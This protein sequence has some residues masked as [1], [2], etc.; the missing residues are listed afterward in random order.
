MKPPFEMNPLSENLTLEQMLVAQIRDNTELKRLA[1]E[2]EYL[3]R[4]LK[5]NADK[6]DL[7]NFIIGRRD[8]RIAKARRVAHRSTPWTAGYY[9]HDAD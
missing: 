8:D 7:T 9:S 3:E 6:A 1:E 2:R 5:L 4:R